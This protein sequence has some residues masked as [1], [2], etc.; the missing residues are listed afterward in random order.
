MGAKMATKWIL[1]RPVTAQGSIEALMWV[2]ACSEKKTSQWTENT[3]RTRSLR[4]SCPRRRRR[5][6]MTTL[7]AVILVTTSFH[8]A[9]PHLMAQPGSRLRFLSSLDGACTLMSLLLLLLLTKLAWWSTIG[10]WFAL[11]LM[12]VLCFA[13]RRAHF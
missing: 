6:P 4:H 1:I 7:L 12:L 13:P 10:C 11:L 2:S 5:H 9:A 3:R 8:L